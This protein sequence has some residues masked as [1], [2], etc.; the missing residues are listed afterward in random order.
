MT[1]AD[2]V[3][4]EGGVAHQE[5]VA[6]TRP[7]VGLLDHDGTDLVQQG[8]G[9]VDGLPFAAGNGSG[10]DL[11][12]GSGREG[13]EVCLVVAQFPTAL[14]EEVRPWKPVPDA[15]RGGKTGHV[16]RRPQSEDLLDAAQLALTEYVADGTDELVT[17]EALGVHQTAAVAADRRHQD[18]Q[19]G[20]VH[21]RERGLVGEE[22]RVGLVA[23]HDHVA[24]AGEPQ[25]TLCPGPQVAAV[26]DCGVD[27]IADQDPHLCAPISGRK[28]AGSTSKARMVAVRRRCGSAT[29][30]RGAGCSSR[31]DTRARKAIW[32]GTVP[33]Q[34]WVPQP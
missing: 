34:A 14:S 12:S 21:A 20:R 1:R 5:L 6:H 10:G 4:R 30:F 15:Q 3:G 16:R 31:L 13:P 29:A 24:C 33:I 22:L 2:V 11:H 32:A 18:M 27:V 7:V 9:G 23:Q 26:A 19:P 8:G 25:H 28:A 17:G